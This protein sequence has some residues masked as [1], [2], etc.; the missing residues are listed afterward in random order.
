MFM[1]PVVICYNSACAY[2]YALSYLGIS[3]IT[4]VLEKR[5][6]SPA[7]KLGYS[8]RNLSVGS[9]LDSCR[10]PI[11]DPAK[12]GGVFGRIREFQHELAAVPGA[13]FGEQ[14]EIL[15]ALA[16]EDAGRAAAAA[17]RRGS[18]SRPRPHRRS[19]KSASTRACCA[20]VCGSAR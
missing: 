14:S 13:L 10:V 4:L 2:I 19:L 17:P 8:F 7:L 1:L 20:T 11:L 18:Y 9:C 16:V 3:N 6:D 5:C 12:D 15:I